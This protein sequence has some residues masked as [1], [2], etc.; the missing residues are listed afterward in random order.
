M[1]VTHHY[2]GR[3]S[4]TTATVVVRV[5][6]TA[7]V[8]V[9]CN[10][11]TVTQTCDTAVNDGNKVF[12]FTGLQPGNRYAY[13][14][15]GATDGT[16]RLCTQPTAPTTAAPIWLAFSSC[17]NMEKPDILA[18][19]LLTAPAND[20]AND[21]PMQTLHRECVA[22]LQG[23]F[24]LGD[25]TYKNVA[26]TVNGYALVL[27][28]GGTIANSKDVEQHRQ[29]WRAQGLTPGL[30]DL[31]R[32]VPCYRLGDDHDDDPDNACPQS[33][34]WYQAAYAGGIE[35]DRA[36]YEVA[37]KTAWKDWALGNPTYALA[38]NRYFKV[39]IGNV[40][41]FC[42]DNISERSYYS[43]TDGPT[44]RLLSSAQE[45]LCLTDMA[46]SAAAFKVWANTKMMISACG[47]N[48]DGW[49]NTPGATGEGYQTQLARILADSRFPRSGALVVTGD[50]HIKSVQEVTAD[51]F[52]SGG[53]YITEIAAGPAT[54]DVITNPNDGLA[55]TSG[56]LAK[57]RDT[58]AAS[59]RGDN[60]YVL[61]RVLPD[62]VE[63]YVLGSRSGLTYWGYISTA[64]NAVRR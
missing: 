60:N 37:T 21:T 43:D 7:S 35:A 6:S 10:G 62:R 24:M 32:A 15:T 34:A 46:A 54:I 13:S 59:R 63:R 48:A 57:E 11:Q 29:Y 3:N 30:K 4:T 5:D 55:Y 49:Y 12:E 44:K 8:S 1:A 36:A 9:V 53:A 58:S 52:G 14:I 23:L 18:L 50:E 45:E 25:L 56:V 42:T 39:R 20:A 28:T 22:N 61:L 47:R 16:G 33:L 31:M 17:W 26:K 2:T 19:K 64:D 40:E 27:M 41:V 51:R 38:G